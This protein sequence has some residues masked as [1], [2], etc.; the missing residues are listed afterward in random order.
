MVVRQ[1][2]P[3]EATARVESRPRARRGDRASAGPGSTS[4][5]GSRRDDPRVRPAQRERARVRGTDPDDVVFGELDVGSWPA[6]AWQA[7]GAMV[8]RRRSRARNE[9]RRPTREGLADAQIP[10]THARGVA[11]RGHHRRDRCRR[12]APHARRRRA[13]ATITAVVRDRAVGRSAVLDDAGDGRR[14]EPDRR[15]E[16]PGPRVHGARRRPEERLERVHGLRVHAGRCVLQ[17]AARA[18]RV[19]ARRQRLGRLRPDAGLQRPRPARQGAAAV[20]LDAVHARP[21]SPPPGG[22]ADAAVPGRER[23]RRRASRTAA[24]RSAA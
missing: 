14:A 5:A 24:G 15:H 12:P 23:A 4:H 1:R 18:R 2:D 6:S 16:Q 8:S 20:L 19:H 13:V 22:S 11:C 3:A 9:R 10:H 7:R 17:L 21:A